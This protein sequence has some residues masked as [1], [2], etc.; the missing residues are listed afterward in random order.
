MGDVLNSRAMVLVAGVLGAESLKHLLASLSI[1][2]HLSV[3]LSIYLSVCL[4]ACLSVLYIYIIRHVMNHV[5]SELFDSE[6]FRTSWGWCK[7]CFIWLMCSFRQSLIAFDEYTFTAI[8]RSYRSPFWLKRY[9]F[10]KRWKTRLLRMI[11]LRIDSH[12][13]RWSATPLMKSPGCQN[14]LQPELSTVSFKPQI[15]LQIIWWKSEGNPFCQCI[16][17]YADWKCTPGFVFLQRAQLESEAG[18]QSGSNNPMMV[19]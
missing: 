14:S 15:V 16:N 1:C 5:E 11:P 13:D 7:P 18:T 9:R 4:S 8:K 10:L 6:I 12:G 3:I 19:T 17:M 2:L